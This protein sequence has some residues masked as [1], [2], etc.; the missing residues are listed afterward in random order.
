MWVIKHKEQD[1]FLKRPR[2]AGSKVSTTN[3]LQKASVFN[4]KGSATRILNSQ[5]QNE[6]LRG[7]GYFLENFELK[8]VLVVIA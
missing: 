6:Y 4:L 1:I 8:E 7:E 3:N 2:L 5:T